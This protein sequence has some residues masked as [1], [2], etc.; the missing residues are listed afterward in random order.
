MMKKIVLSV[1]PG[2]GISAARAEL[3]RQN[4]AAP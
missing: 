3:M 4:G 1:A 2:A